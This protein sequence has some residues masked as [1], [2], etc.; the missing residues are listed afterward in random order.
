M[1]SAGK[2]KIYTPLMV[3]TLPGLDA[4]N[5]IIT[6]VGRTFLLNLPLFGNKLAKKYCLK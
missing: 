6:G 5:V 2:N 1:I 4:G 3:G